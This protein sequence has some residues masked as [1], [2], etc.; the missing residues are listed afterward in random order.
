VEA[1]QEK[2][3]GYKVITNQ[4][5]IKAVQ[6][7]IEALLIHV[8]VLEEDILNNPDGDHPD[9]RRRQ[10]VLDDILSS[11]QSLKTEKMVLTNQG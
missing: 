9:K 3:H 7:R 1:Y 11:I 8:S 5:K 2:A 6:E 4:D 10:E